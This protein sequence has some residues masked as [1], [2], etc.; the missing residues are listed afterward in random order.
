MSWQAR[1]ANIVPR[2]P[3][4]WKCSSRLQ[5]VNDVSAHKPPS[6]RPFE[7]DG[8]KHAIVET[9]APPKSTWH[10][11]AFR[12]G[13][14]DNPF[15]NDIP[16]RDLL[17]TLHFLLATLQSPSSSPSPSPSIKQLAA[18]PQTTLNMAPNRYLF[19]DPTK[20]IHYGLWIASLPNIS[21]A[22]M[23]KFKLPPI[24][25]N[26]RY[27]QTRHGHNH[28]TCTKIVC[29]NFPPPNRL[30]YRHWHNTLQAY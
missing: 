27:R 10:I 22:V 1:Y 28:V 18:E 24:T 19:T 2:Q 23:T 3:K 16:T 6:N 9:R 11:R 20:S 26:T 8:C 25:V 12:I 13:H 17:A 4:K 14:D 21:S 15:S 30:H 29:T 5:S 7:L